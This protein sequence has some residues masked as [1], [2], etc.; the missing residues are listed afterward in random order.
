MLTTLGMTRPTASTT[1]SRRG[2]SSAW[3]SAVRYRAKPM[4]VAPILLFLPCIGIKIN[5]DKPPGKMF[6]LRWRHPRDNLSTI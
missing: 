4:A 3:P 5:F 1:V 6:I 2:E